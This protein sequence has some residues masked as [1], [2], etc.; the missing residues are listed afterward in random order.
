MPKETFVEKS[1]LFKESQY[2]KIT[3]KIVVIHRKKKHKVIFVS[4]FAFIYI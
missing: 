3:I 1:Q 4:L 2:L